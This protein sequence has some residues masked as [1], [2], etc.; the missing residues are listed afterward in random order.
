MD[1]CVFKEHLEP[2]E[3]AESKET[4]PISLVFEES[5]ESKQLS[6]KPRS[7]DQVHARHWLQQISRC[8]GLCWGGAGCVDI[9]NDGERDEEFFFLH[10]FIFFV[11]IIYILYMF[12]HI[13]FTEATT[14]S[15]V[16][17]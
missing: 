14:E 9:G 16:F 10:I 4:S 12:W 17:F 13:A 7:S 3:E 2:S 11:Y 8:G 1:F 15:R 6:I 5:P